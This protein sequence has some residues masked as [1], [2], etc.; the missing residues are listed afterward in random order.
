MKTFTN[1]IDGN[2]KPEFWIGGQN[3]ETGITRFQC[4]ETN[5]DNSYATVAAIELRYIN[6]LNSAYLQAV[7]MDG[8]GKKEL[9]I[10]I[11][12]VILILK[13][14]G[15]PNK[16]KY[17]IYYAK[18]GEITQS[19][20][21]FEPVAIADFD[22]D[23]KPDVLIPFF[24]SEFVLNF[25]YILKQYNPSRVENKQ[26]KSLP[27]D[28]ITCYPVPF[29]SSTSI[30]FNVSEY[31]SVNI[32][33][34]NSLGKEINTIFNKELSPGEYNIQWEAKDKYG[35]PLPSGVYFICLQTCNVI[36]TTKTI[37]LK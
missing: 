27:E 5:G 4:Y 19:G 17:D 8:D 37:L 22:G 32:K 20:L 34:F 9:V 33:I 29:N 36:K 11:E 12:N 31:S 3:F 21:G 18:L 1:D 7:D 14:M 16:H 28:N 26:Y 15:L 35:C 10:D 6:T 23:K 13:F 2:G 25:S 24:D 30:R